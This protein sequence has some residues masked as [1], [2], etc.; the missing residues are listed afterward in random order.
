MFFGCSVTP[1]DLLTTHRE[2]SMPERCPVSR[3][4]YQLI[5]VFYKMWRSMG[6]LVRLMHVHEP[7]SSN[8]K[9][10][11]IRAG[12]GGIELNNQAACDHAHL[13]LSVRRQSALARSLKALQ[14]VQ[15]SDSVSERQTRT[16]SDRHTRTRGATCTA[17]P[18]EHKSAHASAY[19]HA[20]PR[21]STAPV[22]MRRS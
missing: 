17:N 13:K 5:R 1:G 4:P 19:E 12:T 21:M 2:P 3:K 9:L 11:L 14:W 6:S 7:G 8:T 16:L 18:H 10:L 22:V 15:S 20:Q